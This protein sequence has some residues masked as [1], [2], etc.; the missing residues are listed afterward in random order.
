M[1]ANPPIDGVQSVLHLRPSGALMSN[2]DLT[3][4]NGTQA[5]PATAD[6]GTNADPYLTPTDGFTITAFSNLVNEAPVNVSLRRLKDYV[7]GLRGAIIGDFVG[8][9][10]KTMHSLLVDGTG[11]AVS[12]LTAGYMQ[13]L[14]SYLVGAV[15]SIRS[16]LSGP[17]LSFSNTAASGSNPAGTVAGA[18]VLDAL[19]IPKAWVRWETNGAGLITYSDGGRVSSVT[20]PGGSRVRVTFATP[21]DN[22]LYSATK[23]IWDLNTGAEIASRPTTTAQGYIDITL[24]LDPAANQFVGMLQVFGRQ[25]T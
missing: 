5:F 10:R 24:G 11:G 15:G 4:Y 20:L 1:G 6:V 14:T 23:W 9:N 3:Q 25:T 12:T 2:A 18:N 22:T 19:M 16:T 7:L 8:A 13:T 21:F 17:S